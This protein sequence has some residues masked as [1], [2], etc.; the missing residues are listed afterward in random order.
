MNTENQVIE[1]SV[2]DAAIAEM[3]KKYMVLKLT[4]PD[5]KEGLAKIVEYRK[6]VKSKRIEVETTRKKLK[7]DSLEYGKKVDAEAKRITEKL[8]PIENHLIGQENIAKKEQERIKAE[9]QKQIEEAHKNRLKSIIEAGAVYNG[10][11]YCYGDD[12]INDSRIKLLDDSGF[13]LIIEKT[14]LWKEKEDF[15]IAEEERLTKEESD[16]QAKIA[17]EQKAEQERLDKIKADQEEEQRKMDAEKKAIEDEKYNTRLEN[18]T[19]FGLIYNGLQDSFLLDDINVSMVELKTL[20]LMDW[21]HLMVDIS[22]VIVERREQQK[23]NAEAI[24]EQEKKEAEELHKKELKEAEEKRKADAEAAE[25]KRLAD[26]KAAEQKAEKEKIKQQHV[27]RKEQLVEAGAI[28]DALKNAYVWGDGDLAELVTESRIDLFPNHGV[29]W[30]NLIHK[31][32]E[33]SSRKTK[34]I[35]QEKAKKEK[36]AAEKAEKLR[37]DKEK[38]INFANTLSEIEWPDVNSSDAI[39]LCREFKNTFLE[40]VMELKRSIDDL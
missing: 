28:Y 35:E 22:K 11:E 37:P 9:K 6:E 39:A 12:S 26:I 34:V 7:A 13:D 2:T 18:L 40:D 29:E 15:R 8:S 30:P 27:W 1:Y 17:A 16:K 33:W 25:Q 10:Y 14:K 38:L 5:D 20:S 4:G 21:K 32:K 3:S 31:I 23:K 24:A 19:T 36:A